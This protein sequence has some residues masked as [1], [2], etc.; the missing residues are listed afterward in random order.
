MKILVT[1]TTGWHSGHNNADAL[2]VSAVSNP[3]SKRQDVCALSIICVSDLNA[4][5]TF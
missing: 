3:T 5:F 4:G 2:A 1:S